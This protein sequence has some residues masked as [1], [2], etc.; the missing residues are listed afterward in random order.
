[1]LLASSPLSLQRHRGDYPGSLLRDGADPAFF[2][3][4]L[5]DA[6]G[7]PPM[8]ITFGPMTII[9]DTNVVV[10]TTL[11]IILLAGVAVNA[12]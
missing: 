10:F 11:T 4:A 6:E 3:G 5:R 9:W 1:M 8:R 12:L 7:E 2:G